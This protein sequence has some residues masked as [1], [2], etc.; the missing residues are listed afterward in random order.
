MGTHKEEVQIDLAPLFVQPGSVVEQITRLL[1]LQKSASFKSCPT[2]NCSYHPNPF[3]TSC[4]A[5]PNYGGFPILSPL[6][7]AS[8]VHSHQTQNCHLGPMP[9]LKTSFKHPPHTC[10]LTRKRVISN[11][12]FNSITAHL[13]VLF[14]P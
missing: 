9:L 7:E 6:K 3:L 4:L 10:L 11:L 5:R 2:F 14:W 12:K 8:Q 1:N 13:V